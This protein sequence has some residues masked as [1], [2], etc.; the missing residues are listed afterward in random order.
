MLRCLLWPVPH[1][2]PLIPRSSCD[3]QVN[4]IE[5]I[6]SLGGGATDTLVGVREGTGQRWHRLDRRRPEYPKRLGGGATDRRIGVA[7]GRSQRR[8]DLD[9]GRPERPKHPERPGSGA[10]DILGDIVEG[11]ASAGMVSAAAGPIAPRA[12]AQA[13]RTSASGSP[14]A[15]ASAGT[16]SAAAGPI[17]PRASAELWRTAASASPRVVANIGT[18]VAAA[19]PI[20]LRASAEVWRTALSMSSRLVASAGTAAAA[21]GPIAPSIRAACCRSSRSVAARPNSDLCNALNLG[22]MTLQPLAKRWPLLEQRVVG[23]HDEAAAVDG[24]L[25]AGGRHGP[26]PRRVAGPGQAQS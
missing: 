23:Q 4:G 15:R 11:A 10:A 16:V 1:P 9:R 18:A 20:A 26:A 8:N 2:S 7:Q 22:A 19:G 24:L 12:S 13:R 14:R 5:L 6:E 25:Q 3:C 17:A 21:A